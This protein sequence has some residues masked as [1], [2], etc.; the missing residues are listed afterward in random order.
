MSVPPALRRS[1]LIRPNQI[2]LEF[3]YAHVFAPSSSVPVT[4][5][6]LTFERAATLFN[7]AALYSQ[8]AA[9]EDRSSQ[10]GLKRAALYYQ[11]R[12][13][14]SP[15]RPISPL[16]PERRW[17]I[18]FPPHFSIA[19]TQHSAGRRGNSVGSNLVFHP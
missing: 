9:S 10:D 4:L 8:L 15:H 1:V 13:E 11:V 6:S 16:T 7:L 2:G 3:S 12:H 17:H 5:R 19:K 18:R 14:P